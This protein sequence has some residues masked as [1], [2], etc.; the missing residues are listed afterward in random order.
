MSEGREITIRAASFLAATLALACISAAGPPLRPAAFRSCGQIPDAPELVAKVGERIASYAKLESW[1]ARAHSTRS[2][3]SSNWM[4]K[5]TTI[6]E[7]VVT[8]EGNSWTEEVLSAQE[9]EDGRSRDITNKLQAEARAKAEKERRSAGE[10]RKNEPR[11]RGRRSPDAIR[12]EAG[13]VEGFCPGEDPAIADSPKRDRIP[14]A[15]VTLRIPRARE[16]ER[17]LFVI[18]GWSM[19][20]TSNIQVTSRA[21]SCQKRVENGDTI[22][23]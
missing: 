9:I 13:G 21:R 6:S 4:P 11:G 14:R 10:A 1:Q 7:K 19:G 20:S 18:G 12:E 23:I 16:I 3:M 5:S 22:P 2:R 8:L 17:T 15:R